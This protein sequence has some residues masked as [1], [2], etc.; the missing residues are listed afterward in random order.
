MHPIKA[1]LENLNGAVLTAVKTD[2][3]PTPYI[4]SLLYSGAMP[5]KTGFSCHFVY[6]GPANPPLWQAKPYRHGVWYLIQEF[7]NFNQS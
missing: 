2:F 4:E 1:A 3:L 6:A 5:G 7:V